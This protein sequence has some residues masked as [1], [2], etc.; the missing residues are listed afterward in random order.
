MIDEIKHLNLFYSKKL[1]HTIIEAVIIIVTSLYAIKNTKHMLSTI[2]QTACVQ[3]RTLHATLVEKKKV[4]PWKF[5]F[6][7]D[8]VV[9]DY[10]IFVEK[11]RS[12]MRAPFAES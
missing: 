9:N 12:L 5:D 1:G 2:P 4:Y 3:T 11:W 10:I 6:A 8:A 7:H